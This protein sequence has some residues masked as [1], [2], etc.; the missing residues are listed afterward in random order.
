MSDTPDN[1]TEQ[2]FDK[3]YWLFQ[4]YSEYDGNGGMD[5]FA[6]SFDTLEAAMFPIDSVLT[7]AHVFDSVTHRI[8]ARIKHGDTETL[9]NGFAGDILPS[10]WEVVHNE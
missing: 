8:V 2:N 10:V 3:R 5:D 6:G 4:M 1:T 7:A 9:P